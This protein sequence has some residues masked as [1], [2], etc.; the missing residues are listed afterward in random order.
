MRLFVPMM[1]AAFIANGCTLSDTGIVKGT[2][3]THVQADLGLPDV[4]GD[5]SGDRGRFYTPYNRPTYEW[6]ADAPRTFYYLDR[7]LQIT[8]VN[9]RAVAASGI[10]KEEWATVQRVLDKQPHP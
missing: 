4:I 9:G 10:D 3:I 7:D 5:R 6:P 1:F 2:P 8:F